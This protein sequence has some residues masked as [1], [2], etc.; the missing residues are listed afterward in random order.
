MKYALENDQRIEPTPKATATCPCCDSEVVAKCGDKKV[1]HWAHKSKQMC[2][3]W[4]ENE[5]QW[6]RDWK[7]CFPEEWQEVVH[8]AEDGEKHIADV[9]TPSG[10][11]IEFQHSAIKPDEQRSRELFY[12]KMIWIVDG[13]RLKTDRERFDQN[14]LPNSYHYERL[15]LPTFDELFPRKWLNRSVTVYF[16]TGDPEFLICLPKQGYTPTY[17][18]VPRTLFTR[19]FHDIFNKFGDGFFVDRPG[20][21]FIDLMEEKLKNALLEAQSDGVNYGTVAYKVRTSHHNS[22]KKMG[23]GKNEIS[24]F[25]K[26]SGIQRALQDA[27]RD[28]SN[29]R[30]Y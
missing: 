18:Y 24:A 26:I 13:T 7:N 4:W 10:L 20:E 6:H 30:P 16:D 12:R 5:T 1:W 8:F 19:D 28:Q 21:Y 25:S 2:D 22:L 3:H 15:P 29:R 17:Y 27:K 11:V 9:K 23:L 14:I